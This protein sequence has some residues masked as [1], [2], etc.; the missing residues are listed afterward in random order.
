MCGFTLLAKNDLTRINERRPNWNASDELSGIM[1]VRRM[2]WVG[3]EISFQ[4][5][6]ISEI[7]HVLR[8]VVKIPTGKLN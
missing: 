3:A 4:E 1:V 5:I 2:N 6:G 7:H 8:R